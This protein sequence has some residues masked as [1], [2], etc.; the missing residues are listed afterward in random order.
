MEAMRKQ[1][2]GMSGPDSD[3]EMEQRALD[4]RAL[5]RRP[6]FRLGVLVVLALAAATAFMTVGVEVEWSFILQHRGSKLLSMALVAAALGM[7]T[8]VFQTVT[9][10]TILTP[11]VMGLDALYQFLQALLIL[12]LSSAGVVAL[13]VPL[14]FL[15]ELVLMVALSMW[16]VRWL[17]TGNANS[18]H[19]ML[20][21]GIVVGIM[22]RSLTSFAMRMIDPNEFTSLQDRMFANFNTVQTS[23]LL[24]AGVLTM[25]GAWCFWRRRHELDVLSLGRD[26]AINLGVNYQ[27][28]VLQLLV[29]VCALVALS[30]ALVGPV[31]FF[32][33]LVANMAY[34]WMGTRRH[35]WVLP[36]VVLWGV[37]LLLGGQ[38]ILERVLGFNSAISV[39]VEFV[40]GVVFIFLLMRGGKA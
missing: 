30:T 39:V 8:V 19:L 28:A 37:I 35:A 22:F 26:A 18:L 7:S 40:G 17:F 20:L 10:N 2:A 31:T 36:A 5:W 21:V 6:A 1:Q 4:W 38:V 13:G 12:T 29:G 14:K 9:H 34:Q 23:L 33:L 32:G 25:L 3:L 11:S 27:R 15:L 24:P 16:L